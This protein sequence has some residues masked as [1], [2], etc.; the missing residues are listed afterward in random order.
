MAPF[1]GAAI[2]LISLIW[3]ISDADEATTKARLAKTTIA[4][5]SF[6]VLSSSS[7]A[8]GHAWLLS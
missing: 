2:H 8:T 5:C 3:S 7:P 6:R 4:V 1:S